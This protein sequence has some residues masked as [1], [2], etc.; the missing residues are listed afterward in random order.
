MV[1]PRVERTGEVVEP[2]P[3]RPVVRRDEQAGARRDASRRQRR[4]AEVALGGGRVGRGQHLFPTNGRRISAVVENI[5]DWCISRQLWWGHQIP[6][7]YESEGKV[8]VARSERGKVLAGGKTLE[9]DPDVLDTWFRRRWCRFDAGVAPPRGR[10]EDRVR[11]F[12]AVVGARHGLRII[13]LS[14][15][16][17]MIVMTTPLHRPCAVPRRLH[18]RHGARRRRPQDEQEQG[19]TIDPVDLIQGNRLDGLGGEVHSGLRRPQDAPKVESTRAR[20]F[21]RRHAGLRRRCAAL[22]HGF[23]RIARATSISTL[24]AARAIATSANKLWNASDLC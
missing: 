5:Q 11:S 2:M 13:F 16:P 1:V 17:G 10:R 12:S 24:N 3:L 15:S 22:H 14:G 20:P 8:Y 6:A 19:N 23:I 4:L 7:W 21:S 18:P 9:R